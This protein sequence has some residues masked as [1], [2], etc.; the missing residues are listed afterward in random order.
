MQNQK[1]NNW[2]QQIRLENI[3]KATSEKNRELLSGD[4]GILVAK[5]RISLAL[6]I[7]LNQLDKRLNPIERQPKPRK[8]KVIR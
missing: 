6:G 3:T 8:P 1:L 4:I 5:Q 2:L 7:S